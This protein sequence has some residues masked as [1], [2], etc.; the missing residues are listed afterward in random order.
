MNNQKKHSNIK[1]S[2][3]ILGNCLVELKKIESH[4]VDMA[5]CDPPL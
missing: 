3:Y 1:S 4:S 5:F 2:K